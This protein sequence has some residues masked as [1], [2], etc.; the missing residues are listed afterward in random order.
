MT[1]RETRVF[2]PEAPPPPSRKDVSIL[3]A[4]FFA[5]ASVLMFATESDYGVASDVANYFYGSMR[6]LAWLGDFARAV[7]E[8]SPSSALSHDRMI[9]AWRW[10]PIR[11]PHPPLSREISGITWLLFR[12]ILDTITAYRVGV[13]LTY[14]A[15]TAGCAVFTATA[16]GS[17]LAGAGAGLGVLTIPVLFA[18]G[19]FAHT[20]LFL[21]AFWFGSAAAIYLWAESKR[22]GFL[23][24]S[25]AF[26]GA[27]LATKFSGLLAV[28]VLGLWIML[29][30]RRELIWAVPVL[31]AMATAVFFVSNPLLWVDPALALSD[32]FGAGLKRSGDARNMI[33]TEYFGTIFKYRGPWHYP[34]VWTL[35]VIPPT[36]LSAMV[37]GIFRAKNRSLVL[38]CLLNVSVMYGALLLPSAP[39]HDGVR[40]FLSA[41]PFF[42]VLSGLGTSVLSGWL[43]YLF[44]NRTGARP[45]TSV[46]ALTLFFVPAAAAVVQTHP[47]QL[48]YMNL[49]VGGT[50]GANKRGL[51]V[52]NL[53]EVLNNEVLTDLSGAFPEDAVV[54]AGFLLEEFC[55]YQTLGRVPTTWAIESEWGVSTPEQTAD[56]VAC[57]GEPARAPTILD[58]EARDPDYVIVLNRR[59]MWRPIDWALSRDSTPFYVMSLDGAPLLTVYRLQ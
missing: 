45:W 2:N 47:Y 23:L 3:G 51:E 39:M 58:R 4:V 12:G 57:Q 34:F 11:L 59:A 42:A 30:G 44:K 18:H 31:A 54:D 53:K 52:T 56:A 9:E 36:I 43:T 15:L 49:F 13:M 21:A 25:G 27:A 20:D 55:F 48:S 17:L 40:L 1:I 5:V 16:A 7:S 26:L 10:M 32:Y 35:I 29:N 6:H 33:P 37:I 28:P 41:F 19:H 8:G 14:A 38:F 22:I 50:G 46:V 24:L